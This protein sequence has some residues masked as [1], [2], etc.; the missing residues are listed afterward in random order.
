MALF[1][2]AAADLSERAVSL[3]DVCASLMQEIFESIGGADGPLEAAAIA[4]RRV[5][6]RRLDAQERPPP[7]VGAAIAR[8]RG[9]SLADELGV[10]ERR[11]EQL[12]R[13]HVGLSPKRA[14]RLARFQRLLMR[15]AAST[16]RPASW[17]RVALEAGFA[18]QSHLSNDVQAISGLTPVALANA[19]G[20]GFLQD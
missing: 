3:E 14:M 15:C 16:E 10:S 13:L 17:A 20:F 1:G 18:D 4:A 2:I 8:I 7:I 12:F 5:L 19:A 9:S 6:A 11:L